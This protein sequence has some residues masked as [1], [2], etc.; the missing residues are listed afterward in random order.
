M[1]SDLRATGVKFLMT[2]IINSGLT[3]LIYLLLLFVLN[4]RV[5]YLLSFVSGIAIALVLNSKF[6]FKTAL[7]LRKASGFVAAY[8]LQ[9]LVGILVLQLLVEHNTV[10]TS[11]APLCVMVITVPLSFLMSRYALRRL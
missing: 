3:Y 11:I 5:A 8:G 1:S 10:S 4:Y 9:L 6:V 7:T 2:G